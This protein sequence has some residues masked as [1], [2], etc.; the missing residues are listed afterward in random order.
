MITKIELKAI[1]TQYFNILQMGCFAIYVQSKN[2]KHFWGIHLEQYPTFRHFKVYHK[3]N[4]QDQY[5][6]HSDARSLKAAIEH[7]KDHDAFQLNGRK[8]I[9]ILSE[10]VK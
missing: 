2:T 1:D 5:H 9:N 6:R 8:H 7:I 3:H 10:T 4:G